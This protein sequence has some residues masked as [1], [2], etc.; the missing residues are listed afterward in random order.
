MTDTFAFGKQ[1]QSEDSART[2]H[3]GWPGC[4]I[5]VPAALWGCRLHWFKLPGDLRAA[6]QRAYVPGQSVSTWSPA[7]RAASEALDRWLVQ[8][9][10]PARPA[11]S[12]VLPPAAGSEDPEDDGSGGGGRAA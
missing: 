10:G 9:A 7:Y 12:S 4:K 1:G 5:R 8:K 3:C 11:G 2:H 6:I